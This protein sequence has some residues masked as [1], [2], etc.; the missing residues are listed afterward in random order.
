MQIPIVEQQAR[1]ETPQVDEIK[2][3]GVVAPQAFGADVAAATQNIGEKGVQL[4][5]VLQ[6]HIYQQNI[7]RGQA[8][9]ADRTLRLKNSFQDLATSTEPAT[10][11]TASDSPSNT[12]PLGVAPA[13]AADDANI[14]KGYLNRMGFNAT[15]STDDFIKTATPMKNSYLDEFKVNPQLY[16]MAAQRFDEVY[17][18]YYDQVSKH[19]AD[20]YRSGMNGVFNSQTSS[21]MITAASAANPASLTKG[22]EMV[23]ASTQQQ[24]G[25]KGADSETTANA[26][27]KNIGDVTV[28]AASNVLTASGDIGQAQSLLESAKDKMSTTDYENATKH[29]TAL[30]DILQRQAHVAAIG[31]QIQTR[32]NVISQLANN[33]IDLSNVDDIASSIGPKD[34][35]LATAIKEA[36]SSKSFGQI[37]AYSPTDE[38]NQAFS[39]VAQSIFKSKSQQEV[40]GFLMKALKDSSNGDISQDR[41]NIL[42]NAA[43]MRSKSLPLGT[44]YDTATNY[45][46]VQQEKDAAF[47]SL[48]QWQQKTGNKDS[49]TIFDFFKGILGGKSGND[50]QQEAIKNAAIRQ[51]PQAAS[52]DTPPNM[53]ISKNSPI[54][55]IFPRTNRKNG[56]DA[57][58]KSNT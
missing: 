53:I 38:K 4:A 10:S 11:L 45:N 22:I 1:I 25:Y 50:A 37:S 8:T 16:K 46:P 5:D 32:N 51:Y 47:T 20:Q 3:P 14:P 36:A 49:N 13:V 29:L 34:P 24:Y 26:I 27:Q 54:R 52:M 6:R 57:N 33:K 21:D 55:M 56:T 15:G 35:E 39:D 17:A 7:W 9:I 31:N 28:K 30:N 18:S 41:L 19:E 44:P 43:M 42:V 12:A 2:S 48:Q 40:S 58:N 23:T